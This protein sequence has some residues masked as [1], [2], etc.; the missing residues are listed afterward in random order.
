MVIV[1][2]VVVGIVV[3]VAVIVVVVVLVVFVVVII[4]VVVVVIFVVDT[5]IK[6]RSLTADILLALNVCVG[7]VVG[8]KSFSCQPQLTLCLVEVELG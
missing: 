8:V 5:K 6:I 1:A 3:I 2:L 4:N 7:W